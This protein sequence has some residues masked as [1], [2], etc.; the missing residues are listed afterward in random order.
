MSCRSFSGMSALFCSVQETC[1]AEVT[2]PVRL[3]DSRLL[4][5]MDVEAPSAKSIVMITQVLATT[6]GW[7][8]FSPEPAL[9]SPHHAHG[10]LP[11]RK[12]FTS[13]V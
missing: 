12:L 2:R 13:T 8:L 6:H 7:N 4:P 5:T 10:W 3:V 11:S 1:V 9:P